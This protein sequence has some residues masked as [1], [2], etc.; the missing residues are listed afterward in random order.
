MR[1]IETCT[2][3]LLLAPYALNVDT[4]DSDHPSTVIELLGGT[5]SY[6]EITRDCSG[7]VTSVRDIPYSDYG[8]AVSHKISVLKLRVAGGA[9]GAQNTAE[10]VGPANTGSKLYPYITPQIG[11]NTRYFGLDVGYLFPLSS[12]S[13]SP[14]GY[15]RHEDQKGSVSGML[16]LGREDGVHFSASIANNLPLSTG[17]GLVDMGLGFTLGSPR[18]RLWL[19]VGAIPCSNLMFSAKGE[20]PVSRHFSICTRG[21]VTGSESLEYGLALGGKITF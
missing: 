9:T 1:S 5:G 12:K 2:M 15:S 8:V 18:S 21:H 13:T 14:S 11:L 7:R 10:V 20:F 6:A 19:G 3:L 17:G 4:T 16:R